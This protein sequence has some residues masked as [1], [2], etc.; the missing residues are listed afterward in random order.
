MPLGSPGVRLAEAALALA[1][2]RTPIRSI[3][4]LRGGSICQVEHVVSAQGQY[5][6]KRQK[7]ALFLAEADGLARLAKT[8][9]LRIP[10]VCAVRADFI[11]LRYVPTGPSFNGKAFGEGLAAMHQAP[12][13]GGGVW[14]LER[15]N[16]IGANVQSNF[17][18]RDWVAFFGQ[19]RLQAQAGL[20]KRLGRWSLSRE[21]ALARLLQRLPDLLPAS[22]RGS[23]LHGDLWRGNVLSGPGGEPFLIDPAVYVG[24]R[25]TDLAFSRLFGGFPDDFY[26]SYAAT[27]PLEKGWE[28]RQPIY[29]LYHLLNHLNLFGESYGGD[30]D[31]VL[32]RFGR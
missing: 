19:H 31:A 22:P 12:V 28:K 15:D 7:Q 11:L 13:E 29:N 17:P 9:T 16:F 8:G 10:E 2:D 24:D 3:N 18:T 5:V 6:L 21:R 30:V 26:E 27:W 32:N 23:L 14:G 20:A 4:P 25:E 1:G